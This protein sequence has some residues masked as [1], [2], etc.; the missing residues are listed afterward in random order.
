MKRTKNDMLQNWK[1]I[2][3]ASSGLRKPYPTMDP[4]EQKK[5][6]GALEQKGNKSCYMGTM[7]LA[8]ARTGSAT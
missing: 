4:E 7:I 5:Q 1:P 8:T 6:K 3:A 2:L